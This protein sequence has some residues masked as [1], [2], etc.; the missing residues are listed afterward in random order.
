MIDTPDPEYWVPGKETQKDAQ[1]PMARMGLAE[2]VASVVLFLCSDAGS[3]MTG[4][5][6]TV[7]GGRILR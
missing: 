4:S 3:Y 7:D 2:E 5:A 6:V 1:I